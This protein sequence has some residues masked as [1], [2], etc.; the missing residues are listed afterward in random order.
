MPKLYERRLLIT[1]VILTARSL[2]VLV[3]VA[4]HG[5]ETRMQSARHTHVEFQCGICA[6]A[7]CCQDRSGRCA[8]VFFANMVGKLLTS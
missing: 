6:P 3:G 4:H 2:R 7:T 8:L 1:T 5:L